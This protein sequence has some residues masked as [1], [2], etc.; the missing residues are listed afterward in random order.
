MS[1]TMELGLAN[2]IPAD[3]REIVLGERADEAG[4]ERLSL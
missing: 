2:P 1:V 4:A 3:D